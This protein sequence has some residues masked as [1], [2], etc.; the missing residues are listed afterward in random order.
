MRL[1]QRY[2]SVLLTIT[3]LFAF[4]RA[5][6]AA[7]WPQFRGL[8]RDGIS[9]EVPQKLPAKTLLW[10]K[11]L[12]G[13]AH[14]G[15]AISGRFVIVPDHGADKDY[16]RCFAADT[17]ETLWSQSYTAKSEMDY[18]A[19]PRATPLIYQEKVYTLS[20]LGDLYC[21][22][23][24]TGK[25]LWQV[26]FMTA[27]KATV[28]QWG[29]TSSPLIV[30]DKLIVNPGGDAAS[31]VALNPADGKVLWQTAG[32]PAAYASFIAGTFGGRKQ[33]IGY[34]AAS[35]GGWD[36]ATGKRLWTVTAENDGDYNVGTP[37][38]V[39]G[40][41]LVATDVNYAR[42]YSFD[43][44]G[45]IVPKPVATSTDMGPDMA[46]PIAFNGLV[47]GPSFGF[48]CLN[49]AANLKIAWKNDTEEAFGSFVNIIAGND[50]LLVFSENG[51]LLLLSAQG[52]K[53]E[54]L[55]RMELCQKTLAAP[56]LANGQLFIR[57]EKWVYCYKF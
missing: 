51:T 30:D 31:V 2:L 44:D 47:F 20:A 4:S 16:I 33:L 10:R 42:L 28:P 54:I 46:T 39:D 41:L 38:N 36:I 7:D 9:A 21:F 14:A 11:P 56:A 48:T 22:E 52:K 35:L 32:K 8:Q 34:D 24:A 23:L 17:G 1:T 53:C 57:D 50:R 12:A 15:I 40:K 18:G 45:L 43:K 13:V 3:A 37:L 6:G 25:I 26:N 55:G 29:Y 49:P 5:A 19:G 27:F